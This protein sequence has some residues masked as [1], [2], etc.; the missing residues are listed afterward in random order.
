MFSEEEWRE[1]LLKQLIQSV[2][3][4]VDVCFVFF[5]METTMK[6]DSHRRELNF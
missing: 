4:M 3:L 6:R 2:N 1:K 5:Q